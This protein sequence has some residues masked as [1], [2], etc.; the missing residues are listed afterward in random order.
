MVNFVPLDVRNEE[1]IQYLLSCIDNCIQYGEDLE[2][3]LKDHDPEDVD[4]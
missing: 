2:P 1:S 3:K 4:D